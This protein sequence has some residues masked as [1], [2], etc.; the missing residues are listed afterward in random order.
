MSNFNTNTTLIKL[1]PVLFGSG[2]IVSF[3]F[4]WVLWDGNLV[5][6]YDVPKGNFIKLSETKFGLANPFPQL[7]FLF[8]VFGFIPV[9]ALASIILVALRKKWNFAALVTSVFSLSLVSIFYF[10][11]QYLIILGVGKNVFAMLRPSFWLQSAFAIGLIITTNINSSALLKKFA[12]ITVGPIFVFIGFLFMENY[13]MNET[14]TD[15][16]GIKADYTITAPELIQEFAA[17][18]SAANK[19][20]REKIISVNGTAT[21]VEAKSDSTVNIK[22]ADSTGSYIIFSL[23]K[24]QFEKTKN[25]K[26]GDIISLKGAC[27]GSIYS[28][29]LRNTVI[30]FKRSTLNK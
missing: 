12:W 2:L 19:K 18:D 21:A 10:Y 5:S 17:N 11:S 27:S 13:F 9:G 22:F 25:I 1:L 24:N 16:A 3:F 23:E 30:S 7:N 28:E 4:P 6:G 15:T 26:A 20:Y 8:V 14:F 29:I